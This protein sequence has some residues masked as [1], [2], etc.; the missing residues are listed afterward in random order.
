[1]PRTLSSGLAGTEAPPMRVRT[2]GVHANNEGSR[3]ARFLA[4]IAPNTQN[5]LEKIDS[6]IL[7]PLGQ[8]AQFFPAGIVPEVAAAVVA[9][10]VD[11][12]LHGACLRMVPD[13]LKILSALAKG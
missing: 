12:T 1:M 5:L 3:F 2:L 10:A 4:E 7:L 13:Y 8:K 6:P 11:G 9:A